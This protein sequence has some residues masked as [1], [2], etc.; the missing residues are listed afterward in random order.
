M[1]TG[2][3]TRSGLML[4][5]ICATGRRPVGPEFG[6]R[7]PARCA[8]SAPGHRRFPTVGCAAL[9]WL[10]HARVAALSNVKRL[11]DPL[12]S[13]A[14]S[15]ILRGFPG[16]VGRETDLLLRSSFNSPDQ[17]VNDAWRCGRQH[18]SGVGGS[19]TA[20][21]VYTASDAN[22]SHSQLL[23]PYGPAARWSDPL[24]RP[25]FAGR[26]GSSGDARPLHPAWQALGSHRTGC[27]R[28]ADTRRESHAGRDEETRV[29]NPSRVPVIGRRNPLDAAGLSAS[30]GCPPVFD[31]RTSGQCIRGRGT[32]LPP[33]PVR[34]VTALPPWSAPHAGTE[35][36]S[37][38][39][40]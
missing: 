16:Q 26:A 23:R 32:T 28:C 27:G 40:P 30:S 21:S 29:M 20:Q 17:P 12:H 33:T 5:V 2:D 13:V 18:T 9:L 4:I 24:A 14:A 31:R 7:S 39:F 1:A 38:V 3:R 10:A 15:S 25:G 36:G 11:A 34:G 35:S 19:D 37:E 22:A 6:T 8:A